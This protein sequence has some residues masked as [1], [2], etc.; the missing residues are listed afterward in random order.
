MFIA[1][2]FFFRRSFITQIY[3]GG[4]KEDESRGAQV[5]V[6]RVGKVLASWKKSF[7]TRT[8]CLEATG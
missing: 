8:K 5:L 6:R 1:V 2:G 7:S 4:R 3:E